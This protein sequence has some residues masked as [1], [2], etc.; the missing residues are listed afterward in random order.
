MLLF[1]ASSSFVTDLKQASE[2]AKVV[3]DFD[4]GL[5]AKNM[6][7]RE[8]LEIFEKLKTAKDVTGS[9]YQSVMKYTCAVSVEELSED[10]RKSVNGAQQEGT[11]ELSAEIQFLDDNTFLKIAQDLGLSSGAYTLKDTGM[12]KR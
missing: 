8:M 5:D 12:G 2:Q 3:T 6:D 9:S 7:D 10:Y 1:V 4:I 11:E